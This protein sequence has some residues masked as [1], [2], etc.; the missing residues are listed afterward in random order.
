MSAIVQG[1]DREGHFVVFRTTLP[2]VEC[3]DFQRM[4]KLV[5]AIDSVGGMDQ[6]EAFRISSE[7]GEA[8]ER[9]GV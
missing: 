1:Y 6:Y 4:N 2:R 9:M 8:I 7:Y 5:H 3:E